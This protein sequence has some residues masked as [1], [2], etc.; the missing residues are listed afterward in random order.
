MLAAQPRNAR[1]VRCN[2]EIADRDLDERVAAEPDA[3]DLLGESV[4][5]LGLSAR[6]RGVLRVARTIADLAGSEMTER[7]AIAEALQ[8]RMPGGPPEPPSERTWEEMNGG[9]SHLSQAQIAR[10]AC[11][12]R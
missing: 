2:A 12:F 8:L 3:L 10:H 6:V 5:R 11:T 1:G 9:L 4:A 7:T